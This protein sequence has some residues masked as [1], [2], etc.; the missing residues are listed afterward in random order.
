MLAPGYVATELTNELWDLPI[1]QK[2]V[3]DFPLH[4]VMTAGTLDPMLLYLPS[5]ASAEVPG[6]TFTIDDGQTL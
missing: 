6:S 3:A 1:G 4:R 5:D 2:L